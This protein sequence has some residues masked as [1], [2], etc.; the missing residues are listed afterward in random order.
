MATRGSS[1]SVEDLV[2][3]LVGF[4]AAY[5]GFSVARLRQICGEVSMAESYRIWDQYTPGGISHI[6]NRSVRPVL[7]PT[8][9]GVRSPADTSFPVELMTIRPAPE[10]T[11][12]V[13]PARGQF[14]QRLVG[15]GARID[16]SRTGRVGAAA[17]GSMAFPAR[18]RRQSQR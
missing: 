7:F 8:K 2:S 5:R 3:N 18:G 17:P 14:D 13:R 9:E 4:Y 16:V 11:D 10:G 1:F 12:W 15:M 6:K